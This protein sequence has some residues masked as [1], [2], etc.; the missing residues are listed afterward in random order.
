M[1]F[2]D[3]NWRHCTQN[4]V[5]VLKTLHID[6]T[7]PGPRYSRYRWIILCR[8]YRSTTYRLP[9]YIK[10]SMSFGQNHPPCMRVALYFSILQACARTQYCEKTQTG[11][12]KNVQLA[13]PPTYSREFVEAV[14]YDW[15]CQSGFFKPEYFKVINFQVLC[16]CKW[17]QLK[18]PVCVKY[19]TRVKNN[20]TY[21]LCLAAEITGKAFC[22][23]SSTS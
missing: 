18:W 23:D 6:L 21:C 7:F 20:N 8:V 14:W 3:R 5:H 16:L 9:S 10:W 2:I 12:K 4:G 1:V 17:F 15:W 11:E 19:L 13:L 22:D